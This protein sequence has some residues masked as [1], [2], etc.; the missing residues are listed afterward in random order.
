MISGKKIQCPVGD[1]GNVETPQRAS[2]RRLNSAPRKAK[3]LQRKSTAQ[4]ISKKIEDNLS[5][6]S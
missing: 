2:V 3:C 4:S 5:R 1:S 6:Y